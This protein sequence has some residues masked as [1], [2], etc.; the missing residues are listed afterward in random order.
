MSHADFLKGALAKE[1][2]Q[3]DENRI[4]RRIREARRKACEFESHRPYQ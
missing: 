4:Q 1:L 2:S 3:R